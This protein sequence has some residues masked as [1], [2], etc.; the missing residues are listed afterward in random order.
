MK[1]GPQGFDEVTESDVIL[2]DFDGGRLSGD[3]TVPFEYPLHTEILRARADVGSVVHVHSPYATAFGVT[4]QPFYAFSNGAGPFARDGVP[5][6]ERAVGLINS[7]ELGAELARSLGAARAALLVAHGT[8]AVG[9]SVATSVMTAILL[10]RAC[11]LQVLA[12][13][14]G[15]LAPAYRNPGERYVHAES[16]RYLMR[17]W[18]Y[19]L[20]RA[21]AA[22]GRFGADRTV[23]TTDREEGV[24]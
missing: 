2:L 7:P 16:D 13:A 5:R 10:E 22:D 1:A 23:P 17:S 6:F 12:T 8:V 14:A 21:R 11:R 9:S 18:D 24:A 4:G 15:G 19:L 20:R 3:H